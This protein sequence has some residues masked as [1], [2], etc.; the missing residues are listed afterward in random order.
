MTLDCSLINTNQDLERVFNADFPF[1]KFLELIIDHD[2]NDI[3]N[4][5]TEI[6]SDTFHEITFQ[7]VLIRGTKLQSI[8]ENVF[9]YSHTTLTQLD[10]QN[11]KINDFPFE[12]L[13]L[14]VKLETLLLDGNDLGT[15]EKFKSDSLL[16]LSVGSNPGLFFTADVLEEIP[17]LR[18]LN[19]ENIGL[20]LIPQHMFINLT[21]VYTINFNNN[22]IT[23]LEEYTLD[24]I[25]KSVGRL[26]L[27]NN[28]IYTA[29]RNALSG[30]CPPVPLPR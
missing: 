18:N 7:R 16:T 4:Q 27:A 24:P 26:M 29:L 8:D 20:K 10:L 9:S 19:M 22:D 13:A 17:H 2:P 25:S 21:Q 15:L 1:K 30:E 6:K 11:N 23:E 28:R 12:S 5:L 14:Y 3:N